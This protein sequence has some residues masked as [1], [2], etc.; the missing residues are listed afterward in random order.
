MTDDLARYALEEVRLLPGLIRS[1][2]LPLT[3]DIFESGDV[4]ILREELFPIRLC[5]AVG[6][7]G[8]D[9]FKVVI[10]VE[11][12]ELCALHK[13]EDEG[14]SISSVDTLAE[15]PIL[16]AND[17]WAQ[18]PFNGLC[19]ISHKPLKTRYAPSS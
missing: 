15:E 9:E 10:R 12:F 17:I 8:E 19:V 18:C 2:I 7:E 14:G 3:S 16:C 1:R 6:S 11:P 13:G 4:R 5:L